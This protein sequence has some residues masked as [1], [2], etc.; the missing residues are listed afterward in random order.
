V[1]R[2]FTRKVAVYDLVNKVWGVEEATT[3]IPFF[4][5]SQQVHINPK[6]IMVIGGL[7]DHIP[8]RPTFCSRCIMLTE[9]AINIY[10]YK[11]VSRNL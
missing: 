4:P 2:W 6:E 10:E 3:D 5:F 9:T 8:K 7:N 11:F 1:I